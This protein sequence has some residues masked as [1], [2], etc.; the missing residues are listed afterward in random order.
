[1]HIVN[2]LNVT[3]P[4]NPEADSGLVFQ[5]SLL[6]Q[7]ATLRTEWVTDLL[8]TSITSVNLSNVQCHPILKSETIFESKFRFPWDDVRLILSSPY[9]VALVNQ[10]EYTPYFYLLERLYGKPSPII[11]YF[12]YVPHYDSSVPNRWRDSNFVGLEDLMRFRHLESI[13]L[14]NF[15]VTCSRFAVGLL[16]NLHKR[17]PNGNPEFVV[18]PPPL[19]LEEIP[20]E[21]NAANID[22]TEQANSTIVFNHRLYRHY[23]AF[24][25][26]RWL[27]ELHSMRKD[28]KVLITNPTSKRSFARDRRN[29]YPTLCAEYASKLE[30]VETEYIP[31]RRRYYKRLRESAFGIANLFPNAAWSMS[32]VDMMAC[33]KAVIAPRYACYPEMLG[34]DYPF[35]FSGKKEFFEAANSLLDSDHERRKAEMSC[36]SRSLDFSPEQCAKKFINLMET[37]SSS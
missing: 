22:S 14:S 17:Y 36:V 12:H 2:L 18:I 29:H 5:R 19:D 9:D 33:G 20:P 15:V 27:D 21:A 8:C 28:F 35:L 25:I 13:T 1:M 37:A 3:N 7:I 24:Q 4:S 32:V 11:T 10:P 26:L 6:T 23:G 31:D 30:F 16:Q 34:D